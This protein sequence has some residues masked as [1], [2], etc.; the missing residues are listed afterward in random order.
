MSTVPTARSGKGAAA[1]AAIRGAKAPIIVFSLQVLSTGLAFVS[2][3]LLGNMLG[4]DGYGTYAF[5]FALVNLLGVPARLGFDR[6]IVR[7]VVVA[8]V[9]GEWNRVRHLSRVSLGLVAI[10][11]IVIGLAAVGITALIDRPLV[12]VMGASMLLLLMLSLNAIQSGTLRGL[13]RVILSSVPETF[14]LPSLFIVGLLVLQAVGHP[15]AETSLGVNAG[16][17]LI[18]TIVTAVVLQ[19]VLRAHSGGTG[20]PPSPASMFRAGLP[21]LAVGGVGIINR[22]ADVIMLNAIAGADAA[23]EYAAAVRIAA[24]TSFVL[25]SVNY[26]LAPRFAALHAEGKKADLQRLV[27][28]STIGVSVVS[29]LVAAGLALVG[30]PVLGLF[31]SGFVAAYWPLVALVAG[32]AVN[33]LS[34]PVGNL[35]IMTGHERDVS[36]ALGATALLNIALNGALI[37]LWGTTGAALA[38]CVSTMAWNLV[39]VWRVRARLG[40]HP[41][42]LGALRRISG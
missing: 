29:G 2:T 4:T 40:L 32:A 5:A 31:G 1:H 12:G 19:T 21:L 7:E 25:M 14:L 34:G 17:A 30:R 22:Q 23:G 20:A 18:V 9:Q 28:L 27:S 37:P 26:V 13:E 41:T 8:K 11:S 15:T 10:A 33:A 6:L 24:V 38:S 36:R 39:L 42:V 35:L 3:V 16:A